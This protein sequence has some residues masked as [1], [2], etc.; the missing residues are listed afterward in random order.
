[1]YDC[2]KLFAHYYHDHQV[3]GNDDANLVL[4]R[5]ELVKV[6]REFLKSGFALIGVP[7][8]DVM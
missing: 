8:L 6:F 2:A 1:L 7:F 3:L 4:T 5:L